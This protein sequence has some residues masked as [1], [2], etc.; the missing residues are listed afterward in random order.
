MIGNMSE[1]LG[2]LSL[3]KRFPGN[4]HA[5][6]ELGKIL[7]E[8][9]GDAEATE[10]VD[11]LIQEFDEWPGPR[12]VR[13]ARANVAE[14]KAAAERQRKLLVD[15]AN[16]RKERAG[17]EATCLGFSVYLYEDEQT[18][19]VTTCREHFGDP[20]RGY[21]CRRGDELIE[22]DR[23]FCERKLAE[24]LAARPGWMDEWARW[25]N[26]RNVPKPV[27]REY[28]P[29]ITTKKQEVEPRA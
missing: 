3:L 26:G 10:V 9:R 19:C 24:E 20:Y 1:C 16:W 27:A 7:N 28:A 23:G 13:Q 17:H 11:S 29:G 8:C 6:A 2:R 22:R 25:G 12:S 5:L 18:V 21:T 15:Q 4:P 14:R